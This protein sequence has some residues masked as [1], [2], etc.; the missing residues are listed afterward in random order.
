MLAIA[1]SAM[2]DSARSRGGVALVLKRSKEL[3]GLSAP[4]DLQRPVDS[5]HHAH[6]WHT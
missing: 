6:W 3:D 2:A 1:G 5:M 4:K